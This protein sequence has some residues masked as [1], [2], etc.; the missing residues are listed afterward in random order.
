MK[1]TLEKLVRE[2]RNDVIIGCGLIA[3]LG[4]E[5]EQHWEDTDA[6]FSQSGIHDWTFQPLHIL[7]TLGMSEFEKNY[8]KY[9]YEFIIIDGK[10]S[11]HMWKNNVTTF[12]NARNWCAQ[13]RPSILKKSIPSTWY[14]SFLRNLNFSREEILNSNY[15]ALDRKI[16]I[17]GRTRKFT[18]EYYKLAMNY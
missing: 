8:K 4:Y 7:K 15:I 1:N 14:Y 10:E 18:D 2:W 9:G 5:T 16:L 11:D 6:W 13:K 17:Q 12:S 3:G